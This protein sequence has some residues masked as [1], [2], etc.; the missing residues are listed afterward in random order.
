MMRFVYI[1][2]LLLL[3]S[4]CIFKSNKQHL[5]N[6]KFDC[7]STAILLTLKSFYFE[8]VNEWEGSFESEKKLD[9]LR[10]RYCSEKFYKYLTEDTLYYDPIING[11]DVQSHWAN[12]LT[13]HKDNSDACLFQVC[14]YDS[15]SN[16][17][18]C[19]KLSMIFERDTWKINDAN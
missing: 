2:L 16:E 3:F 6:K 13:V 7:D 5:S 17:S 19:V 12:S 18:H 15:Y 9:N 4:S 11:Q 14:F 10:K 8:Y 1:G